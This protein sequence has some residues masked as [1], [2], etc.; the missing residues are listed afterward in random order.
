MFSLVLL[1]LLNLFSRKNEITNKPKL[2]IMIDEAQNI[3]SKENEN[4]ILEKM[5]MELRKY[6]LG[7]I[8]ACQRPSIINQNIL[9]NSCC[10]I[11]HQILNSYDVNYLKNFSIISSSEIENALYSINEGEAVVKT[12]KDKRERLVKI[13]LNEHEFLISY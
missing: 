3:A 6:G 7:I 10:L 9:A 4:G 11:L 13:G 12:I 1:N 5:F 8:L 2:V